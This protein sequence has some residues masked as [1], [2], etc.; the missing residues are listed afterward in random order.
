MG[1]SHYQ[2]ELKNKFNIY[3]LNAILDTYIYIK[4]QTYSWYNL[5]SLEYWPVICKTVEKVDWLGLDTMWNYMVGWHFISYKKSLISLRNKIKCFVHWIWVTAWV[6][7]SNHF[8][9]LNTELQ[10]SWQ[11]ENCIVKN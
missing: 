2:C 7:V 10:T 8:I 1:K 11:K 4:F 6:F 9:A 3:I 5:S